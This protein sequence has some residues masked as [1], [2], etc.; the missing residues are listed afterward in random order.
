MGEAQRRSPFRRTFAARIGVLLVIFLAVPAVLYLQFRAA[1]ADK[2]SLLLEN[3]RNQGRLV[4]EAIRP[5]LERF[6]PETAKSLNERVAALGQ[7][8]DASLKVLFRPAAGNGR[9]FFFLSAWPAVPAGYLEEEQALL[10]GT[11]ILD[12]LRD[13]CAGNL[14]LAL[15]F[16]PPTGGEELLASL[17]PIAA[18]SGCWVVITAYRNVAFLQSSLGRPYWR[19]PEV[20]AAAAIYLVMALV[21]VWLFAD[22]WRSVRRFEELARLIGRRRG[23]RVSFRHLNRMPELDGVAEEFDR[24]VTALG[25][26][27]RVIRQTAEE[28]AHA[29]K[30]PV[31]VIS[32]S[33]E[34]IK[35]ALTDDAHARRAV[36]LI[37]QSVERLDTL[38]SA[39]R[40][41]DQ[42]TAEAIEP[43][44]DTV[45]LSDLLASLI[46][47]YAE[48]WAETGPALRRTI[49]PGLSVVATPDMLETVFENLIDNAH[50]F[51][52]QGGWIGVAASH[53]DGMAEVFIEDDGPG[54]EAA[55]LER[56]FER[57]VTDRP[58]G[59]AGS[60]HFGIGLWIVRRNVESLNGTV[61]AENRRQGG[62]RVIVRLP[63]AGR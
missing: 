16:K 46:D 49:E 37:E 5:L 27:A 4:G 23:G 63:L 20:Q 35:R 62:L 34:P 55:K 8:G 56:I 36:A 19:S 24:M 42:I 45:D 22:A 31:A 50:S 1:D 58:A 29:L 38:V 32:Q 2:N 52:P 43:G 61:Q 26:S 48:S 53:R 7:T 12:K 6:G 39:A 60:P 28:N 40:R 44:R 51:S 13:T 18:P 14:P 3:V 9:G 41:L 21:V 30:A 15:R 17:S 10:L 11:G 47:G 54:V 25:D 59:Q 57:Y 33:V